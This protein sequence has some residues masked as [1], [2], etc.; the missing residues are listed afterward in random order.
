[1]TWLTPRQ[2]A[3][4]LQVSVDKVY[5]WIRRGELEAVNVSAGRGRPTWRVSEGALRRFLNSR[6]RRV[7][8]PPRRP[9][10]PPKREEVDFWRVY[11]ETL[12][13]LKEQRRKEKAGAPEGAPRRS[14]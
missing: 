5:A 14:K 4:R 7:P 13:W 10:P 9:A 2:V 1:M 11:E 8:P 12:E 6:R 3:E